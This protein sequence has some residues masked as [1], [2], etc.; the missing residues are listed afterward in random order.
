MT[1]AA[2]TR[3]L[4][5][6][7][8]ACRVPPPAP[9]NPKPQ[10]ARWPAGVTS[11]RV[12]RTAGNGKEASGHRGRQEKPVGGQVGPIWWVV[13][14]RRAPASAVCFSNGLKFTVGGVGKSPELLW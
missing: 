8:C 12:G 6:S 13:G 3:R 5:F 10:S 9:P 14:T 1:A 11:S 2:R 4:S 7:Q